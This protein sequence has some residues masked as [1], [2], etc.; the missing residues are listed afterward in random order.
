MAEDVTDDDAI[1]VAG[2]DGDEESLHCRSDFGASN[3][4]EAGLVIVCILSSED[5]CDAVIVVGT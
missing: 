3:A 5:E 1:V 2:G 4:A